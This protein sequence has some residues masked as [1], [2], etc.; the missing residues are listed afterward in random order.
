MEDKKK[1]QWSWTSAII[2]AASAV[3]ATSILSAKPKDPT[4]HLIS[5]NFTSLKPSLP[6]VDAEVLLTVH[7]TN[8]NI[9]P[10]NYS[11]TTMSIFYEGS[12]LGSAPVQ[13]GSQPPRS[14]QLLRLPARLKALRLAKHASRVMSDVA[15]REMVL[16]AAVDIAGTARV[17]W[18]DHKFKVRVNSHITVDPV[19]LD[20]IDQENTAQL[21]LFGSDD[22]L[23]GEGEGEDETEAEAEK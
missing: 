17:L 13:A 5:I 8:P 7:V 21:E 14:C 23:A 4:F 2:G 15:K 20:V 9:A 10:I 12:L 6:V 3:A 1:S 11:S 16:D 18:W 22:E 19:F